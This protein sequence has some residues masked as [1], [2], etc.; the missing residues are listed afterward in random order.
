M[1]EHLRS[2][3]VLVWALSLVCWTLG[4]PGG[5]SPRPPGQGYVPSRVAPVS[6]WKLHARGTAIPQR[7]MNATDTD[8]SQAQRIV[9]QALAEASVLNAAR[10]AS[11]R[12]NNYYASPYTSLTKK[13][14]FGGSTPPPPPPLLEIT[15]E[16]ADAAALVAELD[17][18][19]SNTTRYVAPEKRDGGSFWMETLARKG[20]SPWSTISDFQVFRNIK[21]FGAKGDGVSDDTKAIKNAMSWASQASQKAARCGAG[22]YGSSSQNAIVYFPKGNYLVSSSIDVYFGTQIIGDASFYRQ[23]RNFRIDIRQTSQSAKICAIHYQVAQATS[24]EFIELIATSPKENAKTTQ[25]GIFAENGSGGQIADITFTGGDIG[26]LGGNQQFTAQRLTFNGCRTAVQLNWDWGWTWKSIKVSDVDVGFRLTTTDAGAAV[27]SIFIVDSTF[28]NTNTALLTM[29]PSKDPGTGTT[30]ITLDN[31]AFSGVKGLVVDKNGKEYVQGNPSSV[32]T[33]VLGPVYFTPPSRDVSLGYSFPTPRD[34][35]L[36]GDAVQGLPKKPFFERPKPQY[37]T[38]SSGSFVH[39]K[40]HGCKGDGSSD[41]TTALQHFVN[42]FGNSDKIMFIDSGIYLL[43]DTVTIPTGARIVGEAWSQLAATGSKFSDASKPHVMLKVGN[44]GDKGSVE[45]QDLLFTSKGAT[46]G[47]ILVEWN[48][49]ADGKGTAGMWDCHVRLGGATGTSLTSKECPPSTSGTNNGCSV[50]SLMMHLTSGSSAYVE[51]SW[52][53]VADH[54]MDDPDWTNDNNTM[55]QV[56]VYNARGFLVESTAPTWLYGTASEHS[57]FYQYNFNA[58]KKVFAGMIQTES[59]YYQPNPKPPAPL[60]NAVNALPGDPDYSSGSKAKAGHDESWA[61]VIR[62]SENVHIAGAGLYSWYSNY[63]EA[64]VDTLNCQDTMVLM[65]KNQN[66]TFHNLVTIGASNMISSDGNAIAAKDNLAIKAHPYWSQVTVFY[67]IQSN[68]DQGKPGPSKPDPCHDAPA[69]PAWHGLQPDYAYYP[70]HGVR[71]DWPGAEDDSDIF[72]VTLV[73]AS[74][75]D[76]V[77]AYNHS[78]QMPTFDFATVAAGTSRQNTMAYDHSGVKTFVDDKGE[79][80][81]S[82]GGEVD[83][84]QIRARTDVVQNDAHPLVAAYA[85]DHIATKDV[86]QGTTVEVQDRRGQR[87]ANLVVAGSQKYGGY[88]T[89]VDPPAAWMAAILDV[90]GGRKLKHVCLLGSHDAGMSA[91]HGSTAEIDRDNVCTQAFNISE[92]LALGSRYFDVR[93][94]VCNGGEYRTGH[95]SVPSKIVFGGNGELLE[96]IVQ[97]VNSFTASHA[98]LVILYLSHAF[99]TDDSY[100]DMNDNEWNHVF[101]I[102]GKLDH[103]CGGFT[104][105]LTDHTIND[106]IGHGQACV[107]VVSEGGPVRPDKGIY[108]VNDQ[109]PHNDHWSDTEQVAKMASDQISHMTANRNVVA[110]G[111]DTFLVMQWILTL[112]GADNIPVTGSLAFGIDQLA[113][114]SAYDAVF[115]KAWNALSPTSYPSVL[116]MDYIGAV[117]IGNSREFDLAYASREAVALVMAVNLAVASKNCYVGGGT[118]Y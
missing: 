10:V 37:E 62:N 85:F 21:D 2:V 32:D 100:R 104:G 43:S 98:E 34:D 118:I 105:D 44:A 55:T 115:W 70:D 110:G 102:F 75:D 57:V 117:N 97:E 95:Y 72:Y 71:N 53:W 39:A 81:Y 112:E 13:S 14:S 35:D 7:L 66:A 84:F 73:N 3:L 83:A 40:D 18:F 38:L 1:A 20:S 86:K 96:D 51:N 29:P 17:A 25:Q 94:V 61:V 92:Q 56:S 16:I 88:W 65:E 74:P 19:N 111:D 90:I 67:P 64:C 91:V 76:F 101:D 15:E 12:R 9:D 69:N 23:I 99:N 59:P 5:V 78:Y 50:G 113:I 116:L 36:V 80:Q 63:D 42:D 77:L 31:V 93:P 26:L 48:L 103:L 45:I 60:A 11:P 4:L 46:P 49:L 8:L 89:S 24:L 68:P 107:L 114:R 28:E 52:L 54:D 82:I 6:A 79:A 27:G 108:S 33:W 87:A 109:F 58:A 47:V 106:Y 41:D 30:G 22:C